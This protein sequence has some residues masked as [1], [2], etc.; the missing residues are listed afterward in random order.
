MKIHT[1][2]SDRLIA[3]LDKSDMELYDIAFGSLAADDEKTERLICDLLNISGIS[4][5]ERI[6]RLHVDAVWNGENEM[7]IILTLSDSVRRSKRLRVRQ[8]RLVCTL[9]SREALFPLCDALKRYESVICDCRLYSDGET[10]AVEL[11]QNA[12]DKIN[13]K[14]ILSEFGVVRPCPARMRRAELDEHYKLICDDFIRRL[15]P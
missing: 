9:F 12:L 8:R 5:K 15:S 7:Y 14:H 1:N 6:C 4:L 2:S 13:L 10:Y 11:C 3:Q